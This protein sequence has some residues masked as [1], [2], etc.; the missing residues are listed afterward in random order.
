LFSSLD[1]FVDG[2][3]EMA[4][5]VG[6]DDVSFGTDQHMTPGRVQDYT[7]WV[8]LAAAML[9]GGFTPR[10]GRKDRRREPYAYLPRCGRL[11]LPAIME[12]HDRN[13]QRAKADQVRELAAQGVS[14]VEIARRLGM[15]RA[16]VYRALARRG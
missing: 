6:I 15:H 3:K 16:S 1:K 4:E 5:I 12:K 9:R 7:Q 11:T 8:H 14:K 2:L 10:G 13:R